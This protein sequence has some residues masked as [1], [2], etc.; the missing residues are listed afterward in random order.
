MGLGVWRLDVLGGKFAFSANVRSWVGSGP[1]ALGRVAAKAA[2]VTYV[3]LS[4][5]T[6]G[7]ISGKNRNCIK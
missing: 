3:K 4:S 6:H 5:H 1:A 7:R 2:I